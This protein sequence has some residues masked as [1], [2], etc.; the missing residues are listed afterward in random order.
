MA[1]F[2]TSSEVP[3]ESYSKAVEAIY[4]CALDPTHWP[5]TIGMIAELCGCRFGLLGVIDLKDLHHE[6][7]FHAG[8]EE[9]YLRLYEEKYAAMN[10]HV[11]SFSSLPVGA[12]ATSASL[13]DE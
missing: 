9:H 8:H 12:V 13:V 3:G 5:V 7:K 2:G 4:D 10:P 11:G 6:L 1:R